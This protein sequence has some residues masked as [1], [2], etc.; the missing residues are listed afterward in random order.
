MKKILLLFL[1]LP[2]LSKG[3]DSLILRIQNLESKVRDIKLNLDKSQKQFSC[4]SYFALS[5]I[6]VGL[7]A[8]YYDGDRKFI[9]DGL[10]IGTSALIT[11]AVALW[12]DSRRHIGE[13]GR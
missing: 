2:F 3:Q 8:Y 12:I 4:G 9:K 7:A 1:L 13:A 11:T 6:P 5:S 10:A